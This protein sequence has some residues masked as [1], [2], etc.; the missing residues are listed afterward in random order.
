MRAFLDTNILLDI[1][2]QRMPFYTASQAVLDE[3]DQRGFEFLFPEKHLRHGLDP[4]GGEP[5]NGKSWS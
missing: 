4:G 3:C 1:I 5:L 2:E